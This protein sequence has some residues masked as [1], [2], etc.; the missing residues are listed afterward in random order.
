[1][2][3]LSR[4]FAGSW[5]ARASSPAAF[6]VSPKASKITRWIGLTV[7]QPARRRLVAIG[8]IA[9]PGQELHESFIVNNN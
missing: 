5:G 4:K 9:L 6:G 8:T 2:N 7:S 1:M 3:K